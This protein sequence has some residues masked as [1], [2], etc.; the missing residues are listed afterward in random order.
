CADETPAIDWA[1]CGPSELS[2]PL[3]DA[4]FLFFAHIPGCLVRGVQLVDDSLIDRRVTRGLVRPAA[5]HQPGQQQ[6][7]AES[8]HRS[9]RLPTRFHGT[10]PAPVGTMGGDD[11][12]AT[13]ESGPRVPDPRSPRR[14]SPTI[15]SANVQQIS[16]FPLR[17][18]STQVRLLQI[19]GQEREFFANF[20]EPSRK[21]PTPSMGASARPCSTTRI[22]ACGAI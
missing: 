12:V 21:L 7:P 5:G 8:E 9:P 4:R 10:T 19:R 2:S 20:L 17:A 1:G 18:D 22:A 16:V 13:A 3:G 11:I 15:A 6:G 14:R